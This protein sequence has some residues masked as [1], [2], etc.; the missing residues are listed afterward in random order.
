[1]GDAH[2]PRC[3]ALWGGPPGCGGISSQSKWLLETLLPFLLSPKW[4]FLWPSI[5]QQSIQQHTALHSTL[6]TSELC[7]PQ[8]VG[9]A[10][11]GEEVRNKADEDRIKI[12]QEQE[13]LKQDLCFSMFCFV[14]FF[15]YS[16]CVVK[17][18]RNKRL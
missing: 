5:L 14:F 17:I 16:N 18:K 12:C 11:G 6:Q 8:L 3:R 9:I 1:M 15:Q 2:V 4:V 13:E 7:T 10:L